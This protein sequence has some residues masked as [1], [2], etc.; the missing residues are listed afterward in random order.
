MSQLHVALGILLV[1]ACVY[2]ADKYLQSPLLPTIPAIPGYPIVGNYFQVRNNPALVFLNWHKTY[3]HSIFQIRLGKQRLVVVNSF[4]DVSDIWKLSA[5]NS[6]PIQHTFHN[7]VSSTKGFTIGTTPFS[8]SYKRTKHFISSRLNAKSIDA[9]VDIL[10][11]ES[12]A[13]VQHLLRRIRELRYQPSTNPYRTFPDVDLLRDFQLFHLRTSVL[14][15]YGVRL[16]C[17]GADHGLCRQII[18]CENQI[19]R[20]R[21]PVAN[22]ADYFP[23]LRYIRSPHSAAARR[24]RDHYMAELAARHHHPHWDLDLDPHL[25]LD[26]HLDLDP[27]LEVDPHW[28]TGA[29]PTA[30]YA[31]N[32]LAEHRREPNPHKIL[33]HDELQSVCLTMISAGLD[34]TPLNLNHALGQLSYRSDLQA[35]AVTE[36]LRSQSLLVAVWDQIPHAMASPMVQAIIKETLRYFT[37][38]PLSLPRVTTKDFTY[39]GMVF[40]QGT[41]LL[42]NAYCANHDPAQ[43][44]NP[45][46]FD[47]HRW[48]DPHHQLRHPGV[49]NHFAFG[50]GVRMCSGNIL[51]FKQMYVVMSRLLLLFEIK[52]PTDRRL[53]MHLDP[54][55]ANKYPRATSF[56]PMPFKVRLVPRILSGGD[57]LYNHILRH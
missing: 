40:P 10:D 18:H 1:V 36:L 8:D 51:A 35:V 57:D 52:L 23:L 25:G 24:C 46:R 34:N 39:N 15:T 49:I 16:D 26:P 7:I 41:T 11:T 9:M 22:A 54:F 29:A 37:V 17:Y 48:L 5:V 43:F 42:M 12:T 13:M 27:H 2:T 45:H 38:L 14:L 31:H 3:G 53:K 50:K 19:I 55:T 28:G 21:S 30:G 44:G 47:P 32:L 33:D 20:F 6:R 56:E 4:K